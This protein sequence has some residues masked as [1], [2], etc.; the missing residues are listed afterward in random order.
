MLSEDAAISMPPLASWF[1]P[2]A[3]MAEFLRLF[4]LSGMWRWKTRLTTAN[5]QPA[6][7]FYAWDEAAGTHL[8]FA[9]NVLTFR[10]DKV[11]DVVAFAVRSIGP[12]EREAYHRWVDQ[13]ADDKR[14]AGA[15]ARFGLPE[16]VD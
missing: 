11:A 2:R 15:F 6:I 13:P 8:P 4:P 9:L 5:G 14:L 3:V 1:G 12:E 16:Q 7:A 10:G